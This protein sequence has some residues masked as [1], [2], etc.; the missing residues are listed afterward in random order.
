M[1]NLLQDVRHSFRLLRRTPGFSAVAIAILA[2]GI[3]ANTAV[4]SLVNA[5]V[6]QPRPGRIDSTIGVFSRSRVKAEDYRDFSYR[7]TWTF[8]IAPT[9]SRA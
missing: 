8:A 4:F 3:G 5:L 6:F 7:S 1:P 9:R 2:L